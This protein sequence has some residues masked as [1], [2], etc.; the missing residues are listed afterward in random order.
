VSDASG[1]VGIEQDS[2]KAKRAMFSLANQVSQ[3]SF[4]S[5]TSTSS[6]TKMRKQSL[7]SL[8]RGSLLE[9]NSSVKLQLMDEV[10]MEIAFDLAESEGGA[11]SSIDSDGH[12]D[13]LEKTWLM[14]ATGV[15]THS[16]VGLREEEVLGEELAPESQDGKRLSADRSLFRFR[17]I[18]QLRYDMQ[19]SLARFEALDAVVSS[20]EMQLKYVRER[21]TRE[22]EENL[23]FIKEHARGNVADMTVRYGQ[24]VQLQ[25]VSSGKFLIA[26]FK[27]VARLRKDCLMVLL[28]EKGDEGSW[29]QI[30]PRYK[31]RVEGGPVYTGDQ[32][33]LRPSRRRDSFLSSS[34]E[35]LPR[36]PIFNECLALSVKSAPLLETHISF[37]PATWRFRLHTRGRDPWNTTHLYDSQALYMYHPEVESL[38]G[39]SFDMRDKRAF[40]EKHDRSEW[41]KPDECI[42]LMESCSSDSQ[43]IGSR[44]P[45][46]IKWGDRVALRHMP[47]CRYLSVKESSLSPEEIYSSGRVELELTTRHRCSLSWFRLFPVKRKPGRSLPNTSSPASPPSEGRQG[48]SFNLNCQNALRRSGNGIRNGFA[49]IV[50]QAREAS[51]IP[52]Q[53]LAVALEFVPDVAIRLP[54]GMVITEFFL[55][56]EENGSPCFSVVRHDEDAFLCEAVPQRAVDNIYV[57]FSWLS[58]IM[59]YSDLLRKRLLD[60]EGEI[61]TAED[62]LLRQITQK[63]AAPMLQVLEEVFEYLATN[64][65]R[66]FVGKP[67]S[68]EGEVEE[69]FDQSSRVDFQLKAAHEIFKDPLSPSRLSAQ[70]RLHRMRFFELFFHVLNTPEAVVGESFSE[71]LLSDYMRWARHVHRLLFRATTA[72]FQHNRVLEL[73]FTEITLPEPQPVCCEFLY[74]GDPAPEFETGRKLLIEVVT[75]NLPFPFGGIPLVRMNVQNNLELLENKINAKVIERF[76]ALVRNVGPKRRFLNLLVSLCSFED[77]LEGKRRPVPSNKDLISNEVWRKHDPAEFLIETLLLL[78]EKVTH[79]QMRHDNPFLGSELVLRSSPLKLRTG[80]IVISW[81]KRL[82]SWKV[83]E[84][85]L[86]TPIEHMGRKWLSLKA[87]Q[88]GTCSKSVSVKDYFIG[89]LGLLTNLCVDGSKSAF[90]FVS[91]SFTFE[92][93]LVALRDHELDPGFRAAFAKLM[94]ALYVHRYPHHPMQ[95]PRRIFSV[96]KPREPTRYGAR[97]DFPR[98]E[99]D[100]SEKSTRRKSL[101]SFEIMTSAEKLKLLRESIIQI[102]H[103]YI[104]ELSE[105]DEKQTPL[106]SKFLSQIMNL[107]TEL[108]LFGFFENPEQLI[109]LNQEEIRILESLHHGDI[110]VAQISIAEELL[111]SLFGA[112]QYDLDFTVSRV[113]DVFAEAENMTP[114]KEIIDEVVRGISDDNTWTLFDMN[115]SLTPADV[116]RPI[117]KMLV[118]III[119]FGRIIDPSVRL[120]ERALEVLIYEHSPASTLLQALEACVIIDTQCGRRHLLKLREV[121]IVFRHDVATFREWGEES[122]LGKF[123][124]DVY[125]RVLRSLDY[126]RSACK[127]DRILDAMEVPELVMNVLQ[128]RE[129]EESPRVDEMKKRCLFFF[130]EYVEDDGE[131]QHFVF[132]HLDVIEAQVSRNYEAVVACISAVI[133]NNRKLCS[134]FPLDFLKKIVAPGLNKLNLAFFCKLCAANGLG[135]KRNQDAVLQM[136]LDDEAIMAW[137]DDRIRTFENDTDSINSSLLVECFSSLT[138]GRNPLTESKLQKVLELYRILDL[139][140]SPEAKSMN[141]QFRTVLSR[142]LADAFFDTGLSTAGDVQ[143]MPTAV[144]YLQCVLD[145]LTLF[146]ERNTGSDTLPDTV[147]NFR[148]LVYHGLIFSL[149]S[150]FQ[151]GFNYQTAPEGVLELRE[152][153][154]RAVEGCASLAETVSEKFVASRTRSALVKSISANRRRQ[155]SEEEYQQHLKAMKDM[156]AAEIERKRAEQREIKLRRARKRPR[157]KLSHS[158][159]NIFVRQLKSDKRFRALIKDE[160]R[161]LVQ[162]IFDQIESFSTLVSMLQALS[163]FVRQSLDEHDIRYAE[164]RL[165]LRLDRT[166]QNVLSFYT[167]LLNH[168]GVLDASWHSIYLSGI[169]SEA[170]LRSRAQ[171]RFDS[172]L[173]TEMC[174]G[175][176]C[177]KTTSKLQRLTIKTLIAV[178]EGGNAQVQSSIL[179]VLSERGGI[180]ERFFRRI[181]LIFETIGDAARQE[182]KLARKRLQQEEYFLSKEDGE[183]NSVISGASSFVADSIGGTSLGLLSTSSSEEFAADSAEEGSVEDG[184]EDDEDDN[185]GGEIHPMDPKA[186]LLDLSALFEVSAPRSLKNMR[187]RRTQA[188][189]EQKQNAENIVAIVRFLQLC[190]EGHNLALQNLLRDQSSTEHRERC[191]VVLLVVDHALLLTKHEDVLISSRV[192]VVEQ[193]IQIFDFLIECMQGPCH[194]NQELLADPTHGVADL[195]KRLLLTPFNL[196]DD[197]MSAKDPDDVADED[198]EEASIVFDLKGKAVRAMCSMFE[199]RKEGDIAGILANEF[200]SELLF[201]RF[202]ELHHAVRCFEA[203]GNQVKVQDLMQDAIDTM[204]L[205]STI[206]DHR[207]QASNVDDDEDDGSMLALEEDDAIEAL[208]FFSRW[209]RSVEVVFQGSLHRVFYPRPRALQYLS[210]TSK[211]R[212]FAD[213][214]IDAETRLRDFLE[215]SKSILDETS[216]YEFL[217]RNHLVRRFLLEQDFFR[218]VAFNLGLASNF[219]LLISLS[220]TPSP[221]GVDLLCY[222]APEWSA[223]LPIKLYSGPNLSLWLVKWITAVQIF[224]LMLLRALQYLTQFPIVWK[225]MQRQ[226]LILQ[227][228]MQQN[229]GWHRRKMTLGDTLAHSQKKSWG[230]RESWLFLQS[231][232]VFTLLLVVRYGPDVVSGKAFVQFAGVWTMIQ[233]LLLLRSLRQTAAR[234]FRSDQ[235]SLYFCCAYDVITETRSIFEILSILAC[236][237][238]VSFSRFRYLLVFPLFDIVLI[239]ETLTNVVRA[240]YVPMQSL[241]MTFILLSLALFTFAFIGFTHFSDQFVDPDNGEQACKDLLNCFLLAVDVGIRIGEGPAAVMVNL[242]F[243][244]EQGISRFLFDVLFVI[245]VSIFLLNAFLGVL[246][247]QFGSLREEQQRKESEVTNNCFICGIHRTEFD[248]ISFEYREKQ[249]HEFNFDNS[250]RKGG[251]HY[252][253]SQEHNLFDYLGF[254]LYLEQKERTECTGLESFVLAELEKSGGESTSWIPVGQSI[255]L[256]ALHQES[257]RVHSDDYL[258]EM[259]ESL[260]RI[261]ARL[262]TLER[263]FD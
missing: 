231:F 66:A 218:M 35:P 154:L 36:N 34:I 178:L 179:R 100:I 232:A 223:S 227:R 195:V 235:F 126:F 16:V 57:K 257:E 136:F 244:H 143:M 144:L 132:E 212:L 199:G 77:V 79:P 20:N 170:E 207:R 110:K 27:Q 168:I 52:L 107:G 114:M 59:E 188:E 173:V 109:A 189:V 201:S 21:A 134:E 249:A 115:K 124:K 165:P 120:F 159:F 166:A 90:S 87:L 219:L 43:D 151:C 190:C 183:T 216:Q 230:V 208:A 233:S 194:A 76:V 121:L 243:D 142:F 203:K 7:M 23:E 106:H 252:H 56:V 191:N 28:K 175:I 137:I 99:L 116:K 128:L 242:P 213:I 117:D 5:S 160:Q 169:I 84:M 8:R 238:G 18:P 72:M 141:N 49:A 51:A 82:F 44:L 198:E 181:K 172:L 262:A 122:E 140:T 153:L 4:T 237:V 161:V 61:G 63:D 14:F 38:L 62:Q 185:L 40:L 78:D 214:S 167:F 83:E 163:D 226:A 103:F 130:M 247:D 150:F 15:Q 211:N 149:R 80:M 133:K 246:V 205:L 176:F 37:Q 46:A 74:A 196:C 224:H 25:H 138:R 73:A 241:T 53:D 93:L 30:T 260:E 193:L 245:V 236:V 101:D 206:Q 123:K 42:W 171:D 202:V 251:F 9:L 204:T 164:S 210:K 248:K 192:E 197:F 50:S 228:R 187:R 184:Y 88:N 147:S 55:H 6:G 177:S 68:K 58:T 24:V 91:R 89:Q 263:K 95:L 10:E 229:R 215:S 104:V 33:Y 13:D 102:L 254:I 217:A 127:H 145:D 47:S 39:G 81:D 94:H 129:R 119:Q 174:L 234:I 158:R 92:L 118:H 112:A 152:P 108:M 86:G 71:C 17:I 54:D 19:K 220:H 31:V 22:H 156:R 11:S 75:Q 1:G 146:V 29:F 157:G 3:S 85:N 186:D 261:T 26:D 96:V 250:G 162:R 131:N 98:F 182:I 60:E 255:T 70:M 259:K 64:R 258:Q 221:K 209:I 135:L 239:N 32:L 45:G 69:N 240:V 256:G 41:T 97:R 148:T 253:T 222:F 12:T 65:T 200:E 180:G 111:R 105:N 155:K 125:N 2:A 48:T 225:K 113:L 139:L 67:W